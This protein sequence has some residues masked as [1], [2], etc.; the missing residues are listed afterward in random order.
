MSWQRI[1]KGG[2]R[3]WGKKGAGFLFSDGQKILLLRRNEKGDH[4]HTWCIPGGKLREEET[5]LGGAQRET[6]EETGHLPTCRRLGEFDNKDGRHIFR[7]YVCQVSEPYD[8][9]LSDEH[10]S[11]RW[12]DMGEAMNMKLH[13]KLKELLPQMM[14][15]I[16][17]KVGGFQNEMSG[18]AAYLDGGKDK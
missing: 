12:V 5:F 10:D 2:T 8:V 3:Y 11:F 17:D 14:L 13:P 16:K 9:K 6:R 18:F 4:N 1:G 15:L 7:T